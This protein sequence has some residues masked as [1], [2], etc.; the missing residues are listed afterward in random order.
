M[1][2][3]D[4]KKS[5][6][7]CAAII[8]ATGTAAMAGPQGKKVGHQQLLPYAGNGART[9]GGVARAS[10]CDCIWDNGPHDY[11]NGQA[12]EE[13]T[14]VSAAYTADDFY[15]CPGACYRLQGIIAYGLT[16]S[17][18]TD[19][20]LDLY[21]DCNGCPDEILYSYSNPDVTS[22]GAGPW[23]HLT[24][25]EYTFGNPDDSDCTSDLDT[26]LHGGNLYW[27]SLVLLGDGSGIDRGFFAT[28]GNG[29][30][31][32]H[33][34]KFKSDKFGYPDWVDLEVASCCGKTD[35]AFTICAEECRLLWDNGHFDKKEGFPSELN[36]ALPMARS[37]DNFVL[38]PCRD[39]VICLIEA[40]IA[41]NCRVDR[42]KAELYF[43]DCFPT[44]LINTYAVDLYYDTGCI[45]TK[46]G[47]NYPIYCLT[48][49]CIDEELTGGCNYWVSVYDVGTG[50][51][52]ERAFWM[53]NEFCDRD[54]WIK[55][56]EGMHLG[57]P[58]NPMTWRG[59][60]YYIGHPRDF[61]F[62]IYG[63]ELTQIGDGGN[64]GP[65]DMNTGSTPSTGKGN[66]GG[67]S[68]LKKFR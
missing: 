36:T 25:Y 48:F 45:F 51:A 13:G 49:D 59:V 1:L 54:C 11:F 24:L 8:A 65:V 41:T 61:S 40:Y 44:T 55:I 68:T 2:R 47:K 58:F 20:R 39:Y 28:A 43:G 32:G 64:N 7:L 18:P 6:I 22:L 16:T 31:K 27:V 67:S 26:W 60:S 63:N 38:K 29:K 10:G 3:C 4:L 14:A 12:S 35:F 50:S 30:I 42:S 52:S 66:F 5:T 34:G 57:P 15:L 23:P 17:N 21:S 33:Q 56:S 46:D 53:F 62:R 9:T 37:A 19:A